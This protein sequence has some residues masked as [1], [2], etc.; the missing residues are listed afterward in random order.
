VSTQ[1]F[2]NEEPV[3]AKYA[4][5]QSDGSDKFYETT[6]H[7]GD[8]GVYYLQKRWGR[9]PDT[10]AGQIRVEPY[11][12]LSGAQHGADAIFREKLSKGY[13]IT[14]RPAGANNKVA[15][16]YGNDYYSDEQA[17]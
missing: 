13:W 15:K 6:I 1:D 16:E 8:D 7:F 14:E 4:V 3:W 2:R 12:T 11:H 17:F 10:G 5:Y 9:R